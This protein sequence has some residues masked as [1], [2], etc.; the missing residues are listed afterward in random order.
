MR[1]SDGPKNVTGAQLARLSEAFRK[2]S[3]SRFHRNEARNAVLASLGTPLREALRD[4]DKLQ[5]SDCITAIYRHVLRTKSSYATW[6]AKEWVSCFRRSGLSRLDAARH[7]FVVVAYRFSGVLIVDDLFETHQRLVTTKLAQRIYGKAVVDRNIRLVCDELVSMGNVAREGAGVVATT[8]HAIA[9]LMLILDEPDVMRWK[10]P[11]RRAELSSRYERFRSRLHAISISLVA[12]GVIEDQTRFRA[13]FGFAAH[14]HIDYR[15]KIAREWLRW[16]DRWHKLST[17]ESRT[18]RRIAASVRSAGR[19]LYYEHPSVTSP[20]QWDARL[21]AQFVAAVSKWKVGDY[22]DPLPE[23]I[24]PW[25]GEQLKPQSKIS[26]LSALRSFFLNLQALEL[27]PARF[28]PVTALKNPRSVSSQADVAPRVLADDV[29]AKLL[30]AG[31]TL[32]ASDLPKSFPYPI[33]LARAVAINWLFDGIR[34]DE[35]LR[36]EVGCI[37]REPPI[38]DLTTGETRPPV[39]YLW[40]P[41][42]KYKGSFRKPVDP[43]VADAVE[44]WERIRPPQPPMLDRKTKR[45][46]QRLF[47]FRGKPVGTSIVNKRIVPLLCRLAGV[48]QRDAIGN[49]TSHRARSTIA[50]Q[51]YNAESP[52]GLIELMEW[53]GHRKLDS[54]LAY[55]KANPKRLARSYA[56]ADYFKQNVGRINVLLD[57]EVIE[58]GLAAQGVTYKY[59]DLGHGFC[60]HKFFSQCPHRMACVRCSF[61]LPKESETAMLLAASANNER[62][63]EELPLRQDEVAAARGDADALLRL[64]ESLRHTPALDGSVPSVPGDTATVRTAAPARAK[65]GFTRWAC[66]TGPGG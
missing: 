36:L 38:V 46:T 34:N 4:A 41:A 27:I 40:V 58:S 53:L 37:E 31:I 65:P 26:F 17:L 61:Y 24:K 23:N 3:G 43:I 45:L 35:L 21:A 10:D 11:I 29:W 48:P 54:V 5:Q 9:E 7:P 1:F 47:A 16:I 62:L 32:K 66:R 12:L 28:N 55:V 39:C 42:N 51:L 60:K 52:L 2:R 63:V 8:P 22:L 44:A 30:Y 49:I 18:T 20:L 64:T 57:R 6:N 19:W 25:V 15:A 14:K 59:Y 50:S 13:P 33:E 56:D